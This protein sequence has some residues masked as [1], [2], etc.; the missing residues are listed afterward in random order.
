MSTYQIRNV[1]TFAGN[2]VFPPAVHVHFT[3]GRRVSFFRKDKRMSVTTEYIGRATYDK[4]MA[5]AKNT[6][7]Y[8]ALTIN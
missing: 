5:I 7:E 2:G 1:E 6:P 4:Y 8:K 3:N